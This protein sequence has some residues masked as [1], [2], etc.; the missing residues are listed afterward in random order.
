MIV[1]AV[2][3]KRLSEAKSRLASRL[4][5]EERFALVLDLLRRTV[6]ALHASGVIDRIA[7]ATSEL[8]LA[9]QL[10]V[11]SLPDE[12]GLNATLEGVADWAVRAGAT[13]LLIVPADLPYI[14]VDA[15]RAVV[16][17]D[18]ARPGI[19]I[20]ST[21]DGGTGLLL[22]TPPDV[23]PPS[24]GPPSFAR[25]LRLAQERG[26]PV[27]RIDAEAF[28]FDLDTPDDLDA[29]RTLTPGP[30]PSRGE[31]SFLPTYSRRSPPRPLRERGGGG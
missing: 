13:S 24:F 6:A 7:L 21:Q 31:G 28:T 17:R 15:V 2:P 22:L 23:I 3:V 10:G 30:S 25:H 26:V 14:T 12:G 20:A 29:L 8:G 9:E 19:A 27:R 5:D 18:G 4:S 11:E 1:A 16:E